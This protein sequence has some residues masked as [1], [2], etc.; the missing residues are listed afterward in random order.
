MTKIVH[1]LIAR[2]AKEIC[3]EVYEVCATTDRFYKAWPNSR[4]FVAVKWK[5]FIGDARKA[6]T[7]MLRP[8]PGTEKDPDGP[9]YHYSQHIRDEVFEAL[10]I[11]GQAKAPAPLDLRQLRANAGFDPDGHLEKRK[12][13]SG[14]SSAGQTLH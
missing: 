9:K 4:R 5:E 8:I 2:T 12:L 6:L 3:S 7:V 13:M 1:N 11:D 10:L 14:W